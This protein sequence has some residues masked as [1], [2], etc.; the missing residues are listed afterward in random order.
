MSRRRPAP[1]AALLAAT[2]A[3]LAAALAAAGAP[4]PAAAQEAPA[5]DVRVD[6]APRVVTLGDRVRVTVIVRHDEALLITAAPPARSPALQLIETIPAETAALPDGSLRTEAG[7]TFA[8]FGTGV[9]EPGELRVH[10]LRENGASGELRAPAPPFEVASA[11]IGGGGDLRPL[12]PQAAFGDPPPGWARPAAAGGAL[13]A[14]ALAA[15]LAARRLRRRPVPAPAAAPG[16][17]EDGPEAVARRRLEELAA[18][19]ALA[20][21]D[22]ERFYGTLSIV[23]REYLRAR[24]GFNAPALATPELA[25]GMGGHGVGRWQTRLAGGLL[26]R[27]DAAVYAGRRPDP[28]S[29]DRDLTAA[30][31]V[32]ELSRGGGGAPAAAAGEGAR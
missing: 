11:L 13:L 6:V 14:L 12:K 21:G 3:L 25:R 18:S 4:L 2:A 10:W 17:S 24:F 5:L 28:A 26:D 16:R 22:Y 15:F 30:F 27:C 19:G 23:L 29:A 32:V 7:F 1:P 8:A 9:L 20:D 31:E